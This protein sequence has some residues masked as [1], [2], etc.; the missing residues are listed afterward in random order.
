MQVDIDI[1]N[2]DCS[3]EALLAGNRCGSILAIG[4]SADL[5]DG[6]GSAE[7]TSAPKAK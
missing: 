1:R 6:L 3:I 2:Q 7:E 4:P 5:V